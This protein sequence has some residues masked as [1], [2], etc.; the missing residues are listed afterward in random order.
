MKT[1]LSQQNYPGV[2]HQSLSSYLLR[3]NYSNL[4]DYTVIQ[5]TG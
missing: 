5:F 1:L 4:D 3:V 2:T